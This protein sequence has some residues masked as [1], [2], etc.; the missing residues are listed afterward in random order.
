[1]AKKSRVSSVGAY[2]RS[3]V[4]PAEM[5]VSEAAKRLGVGRPALSNLLNGNASLSPEMAARLEQVF[6]ADRQKLVELQASDANGVKSVPIV[7]AYVPSFLSV[8]ARQIT[9]WPE[10]NIDARHEFP[11]FL[12]TLVHSTGVGLREVDFPGYDNAER[13]GWDG[14]TDTESATT[15]I[16]SGKTCWE[17]GTDGNPGAKAEKDYRARVESVPPKERADCTFVF[18]TPRNWT[19]KKEWAKRKNALG[20]WKAV[21]ALDAS[22][23][24]QWLET[25]IAGRIWLAEKLGIP[26]SGFETL[27]QHWQRW[28]SASN[29]QLT[30]A[31][32]APSIATHRA[33]FKR[34]LEG[35]EERAF[36][37][38]AD[39][40]GE[41]LAFLACLAKDNEVP[42]S[43]RDVAVIFDSA[44]T[45]RT[46]AQ[47]SAL[48]IPIVH[49][50]ELERELA[51]LYRRLRCVIVR[52]R[53]AV[54][55]EPDAALDLLGHEDFEKALGSMKISGDRVDRLATESGRSPT[56]LRRRLSDI[57]ALRRPQWAEDAN[58][59]RRLVPLVLVGTWH[60]K[61][62]ADCEILSTLAGRPYQ[63]IEEDIV[64]FLR[65]DDCPVWSAGEYRGL[66]SKIDALFAIRGSIT[67]KDVVDFLDLAEYALSETD[68]ALQLPEET[69]WAANI[70]GKVRNHSAALREGICESMV[71]L[72][73]HGN[74]LFTDRLGLNVEGRVTLL[75]RKL[76]LP[77]TF[78][79][80]MSQTHALA[81]YA[82]AAP[83]EFLSIIEA[84]LK[85]TEPV[86]LGLLT[87]AKGFFSGPSRTGLLSALE[88]LAW[89]PQN[90]MRVTDILARLSRTKIDDNWVNKPINSLHAVYRSWMPQTA[91]S[92]EDRKRAIE[93]L[94]TRYPDV[95]WDICIS[96]LVLG[97]QIGHYSDRPHW[98]SDASGAGQP[99]SSK[100]AWAFREKALD[101][102][103]TWPAHNEKT[104]GDLVGRMESLRHS[105]Q[106]KIW[107]LIEAW[108]Q[109][110]NDQAKS[111]LRERIR[112][113]AFTR[114]GKL[115]GLDQTTRD[116][117]RELYDKLAPASAA[118]RHAWLFAKPWIEESIEELDDVPDYQRRAE[119]V[120]QAR[121]G[122]IA[123]VWAQERFDGIVALLR[124]GEATVHV[125]YHA[126]PCCPNTSD[127]AAFMHLCLSLDAS[128]AVKAD[129]CMQGFLMGPL[130]RRGAL[131]AALSAN[132]TLDAIARVFRCAPFEND[133]WRL[134]DDERYGE[135]V[136]DSYWRNVFPYSSR[137]HT[138]GELIELVDRLLAVGR[139]RAAFSAVHMD[140]ERLETSRLKHLMQAIGTTNTE[141]EGSFPLSGYDIGEALK[142]LNSR[143]GVGRD[144]MAQLEF[145]FIEALD[146]HE[147]DY[148]MPN[149]ER[150]IAESP[151][152]FVHA[153][154]LTY[155]RR[156][157]GDD[158]PEL[159]I[160]DPKRRSLVGNLTHR[161]LD[162]ASR[163]PGTDDHGKIDS[164]LLLNW[165]TEV[166]QL[167]AQHGRVETGD[168]CIG[169]LLAKAPADEN[170][171]WPCRPVCEAMEAVAAEHI[172]KGF[173]MGV[174]NS[175]GAV[176]RGEGGTQERELA[177][178]Y[179]KWAEARAFEFPYVSSALEA[180]AQ[181]YDR[182]A[183]WEDSQTLVRRRLG[184]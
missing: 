12:R 55:E 47:S 66:A 184:S 131:I 154:A 148:G 36:T 158:P 143:S 24:E 140:V 107:D 105:D 81:R 170:G 46:L 22:D 84:D 111:E 117:A 31:I 59:A 3:D 155:K 6:G 165:I 146:R 90:L 54:A 41:A 68:P 91:A 122:A 157:G 129:G 62:A 151:A 182:E 150:Q 127:A 28:S 183:E 93:S 104:L 27:E 100:E 2:I 34:W 71:L 116:R 17:L 119:R 64:R 7:G 8:K 26:T 75:V 53:N 5:S 86:V 159:T 139:P 108:S 102:V 95:A 125:G 112:L 153:V 13:K 38:A 161:L 39:S 160:S 115:R 85:Q 58:V 114:R 25:S 137:Q 169:N 135:H 79:K 89:K 163:M 56:I 67:E 73:V 145:I 20:D 133:T 60:A 128:L 174:R 172:A 70:Y 11:V 14:T 87:P 162:R 32:F 65:F 88:C 29:P 118:A 109:A 106:E 74:N 10:N 132:E 156:D 177:A 4:I 110:A 138:E 43:F 173:H 15:W 176:W 52:P 121:A 142:S 80:L 78:E 96:E 152:A 164:L 147:H 113:F 45:L 30:E 123:E 63:E 82:E 166:R 141:P 136:K 83:D 18:A 44:S 101:V 33:D 42:G 48:F 51:P 97:R 1:V 77:L 167:L 92:L 126:I 180:V 35:N 16:P 134:L 61:S 49:S 69:R 23:L 124:S 149:L 99:V 76:L 130:E 120:D 72:A 21:R 40:K 98:R 175:R 57:E 37:V 94:A 171:V 178:K 19:G 9:A 103:L 179:R 181:S 50:D 168:Q 144:E